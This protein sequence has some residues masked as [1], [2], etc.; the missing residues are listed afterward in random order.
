[1]PAKGADRPVSF[2]PPT[3]S[4]DPILSLV[5]FL[6]STSQNMDEITQRCAIQSLRC[7]ALHTFL[8]SPGNSQ[9]S[10]SE[11]KEVVRAIAYHERFRERDGVFLGHGF[12]D[13]P[14]VLGCDNGVFR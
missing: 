10:G 8:S 3:S 6:W 1:M 9:P 2:I 11:H 12:Q 4:L 7:F 5:A 14:F 13:L